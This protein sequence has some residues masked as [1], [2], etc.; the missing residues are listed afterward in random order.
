VKPQYLS[1]AA[2]A[3][4]LAVPA[5]AKVTFTGYADLRYN[6]GLNLSISGEPAQ[7]AVLGFSPGNRPTRGFNAAAV[8]LFAATQIQEGL[9]FLM[10]VD[11]RG[12]GATVGQLQLLY[13]YL[14]WTPTEK[15]WVRAGRITL[16][17]GYYN[18]NRFYPFQRPTITAPVFQSGILGLPIADWGVAAQR[19]FPTPHFD[20]ET[21]AYVVNGYGQTQ[22]RKDALRLASFPGGLGISGNLRASDNNHKPAVGGRAQLSRIGGLDVGTGVSGY[23]GTWDSAGLEPMQLLA[24]HFHASA[25]GVT[26]LAEALRLAV[27]GDQG[28]ALSVGHPNWTTTGGFTKVSYEKLKVREKPL[29]PYFQFEHYV[30]TPNDGGANREVLRSF[31]TGAMLRVAPQLMLKAEYLHLSY[32]VPFV[33]STPL[34][35]GADGAL[36]AAV[37]TF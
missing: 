27:R 14:N 25:G 12:V 29:V 35:L 31:S 15:T 2:L 22:S 37:V 1:A 3:V 34:K 11:F 19:T 36:L 10:D 9:E 5:R 26:V 18:E 17:Y 28:F 8:G 32:E 21:A 24:A 4:F 33:N 6:A 16:P 13:A 23:W 20:V 7:L 30:T